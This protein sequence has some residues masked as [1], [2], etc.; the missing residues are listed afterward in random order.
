MEKEKLFLVL[1]LAVIGVS[2]YYFY[3]PVEAE[4]FCFDAERYYNEEPSISG[5][6]VWVCVFAQIPPKSSWKTRHVSKWDLQVPRGTKVCLSGSLEK[7][8]QTGMDYPPWATHTT[9][10]FRLPVK[11][12]DK[13][14]IVAS[15]LDGGHWECLRV[16]RLS[17]E[18]PYWLLFPDTPPLLKGEG[19]VRADLSVTF[20]TSLPVRTCSLTVPDGTPVTVSWMD[21]DQVREF[22]GEI[23]EGYPYRLDREL[24]AYLDKTFP[25]KPGHFSMPGMAGAHYQIEAGGRKFNCV[26]AGGCGSDYLQTKPHPNYFDD[27][28]KTYSGCDCPGN[29]CGLRKP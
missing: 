28:C 17:R 20:I 3:S 13:F 1:F 26:E 11:D 8:I 4:E 9:G 7:Q 24:Q 12:G 22:H 29:G 23:G 16:N 14:D 10:W 27:W 25:R 21:G 5:D 2:C 6:F 18:L 19:D 15:G